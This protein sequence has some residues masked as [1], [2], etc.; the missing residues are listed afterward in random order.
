[1]KCVVCSN[2]APDNNTLCDEC[3]E[4]KDTL[5]KA[6]NSERRP[7]I[8]GNLVY[9]GFNIVDLKEDREC[10]IKCGFCC[11]VSWS[12]ILA[13]RYRFGENKGKP[14]PHLKKKGCELP[15]EKRPNGCV[16]FLCPLAW[17]VQAGRMTVKIAEDLLKKYDGDTEKIAE[18]LQER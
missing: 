15:R 12:T 1:M 5:V 4:F 14:C 9:H 2:E 13:L 10:P 3:Q 16:A 17:H 18:M 7:L 6:A 11:R 8:T